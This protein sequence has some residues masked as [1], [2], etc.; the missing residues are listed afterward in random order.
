[1]FYKKEIKFSDGELAFLDSIYN[2]SMSAEIK[3]DERNILLSAK[4]ELEK[5]GNVPKSINDL[6]NSFRLGAV[7]RS[8][9]KPVSEFYSKLYQSNSATSGL[10]KGVA[11]STALLPIWDS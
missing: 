3:S 1:M 6:M 7:Q 9:S 2:L 5:T 10:T 8:L 4:K 11:L